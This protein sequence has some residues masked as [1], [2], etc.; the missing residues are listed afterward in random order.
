MTEYSIRQASLDDAQ[1]LAHIGV[2][3]FVDSYTSEIEGPAMMAH[4]TRE[5]SRAVYA[6]YLEHEAAAWL[7][8]HA[9]TGAPM[10]YALV[11]P[12]DLPTELQDGDLEL[13]RIY[14][15]SRFH[16]S[17]AGKALLNVTVEHAQN[18]GAPRLL[19]GTYEENFRAVAFYQRE[20]F[21]TI[22]TRKFQ[23]GDKLFDDIIMAR[24]IG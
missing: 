6:T 19:L 16:G 14:L 8:E 22:G 13:K 12:P 17:G 3:T 23:V 9:E 7:L 21:E 24:D 1:T 4:C 5:H 20:G 10:G 11:C 2:A 15:L 18:L